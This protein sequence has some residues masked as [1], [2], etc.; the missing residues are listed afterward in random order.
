MTQSLVALLDDVA[1]R[2]GETE[3]RLQAV[4]NAFLSNP[5][6]PKNWVYYFVKYPEMKTAPQGAYVFGKSR[7]RACRLEGKYV[8]SFQDPF[9]VALVA[10]AGLINKPEYFTEK[11]KWFY[12]LQDENGDRYLTLNRSKISIACVEAGWKLNIPPELPDDQRA[13]LDQKLKEAGVSVPDYLLRTV[14]EEDLMTDN[15]DRIEKGSLLL[16]SLINLEANA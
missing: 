3:S 12:G 16:T 7:F 15:V 4:T 5:Q 13:A 10:K 11:W 8:Y 14:S 1:Q 9:L 2:E 6:T